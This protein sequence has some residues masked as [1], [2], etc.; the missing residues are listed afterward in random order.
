MKPG[1]IVVASNMATMTMKEKGDGVGAFTTYKADLKRFVD[2]TKNKG[3]IPVLVTSI[4][5]ARY[6]R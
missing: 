5:N 6:G 3:G 2:G 4:G 1:V